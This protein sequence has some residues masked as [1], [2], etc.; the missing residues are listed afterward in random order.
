MVTVKELLDFNI[1]KE[2]LLSQEGIEGMRWTKQSKGFV[3][4]AEYLYNQRTFTDEW[5]LA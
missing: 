1:L 4:V 2:T 5:I 3:Y